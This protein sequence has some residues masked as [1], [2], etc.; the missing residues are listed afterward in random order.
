MSLTITILGCGSS[1]GVPRTGLQWGA[2]NPKNPKNWR[3]RCSILIQKIALNGAQTTVLIDTSPDMRMQLLDA[4]VKHL[5]AVLYTHG[6]ADHTH[7]IDDLRPL[8]QLNRQKIPVYC[9]ERTSSEL[10]EKFGYCFATPEGSSYP[11]MVT[12]HR[13]QPLENITINGAGG[14]L[15]FLPIPVNHG[16]IDAL[17][18]RF[19]DVCYLPDV[20]DIP[21]TS[22]AHLAGLKLWILDALRDTPHVSHFSV[23]DAL[24]W[25][26]RMR[27]QRAILTNLNIELDYDA[28]SAALPANIVAAYDGMT[29]E[30]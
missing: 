14:A 3:R 18:F 21:E 11:P 13:I 22:A 1:G 2:C 15:T 17:G 29:V 25:I 27:P 26:A 4:G 16:D 24:A 9:D 23:D 7:G 5:D 19:E 6:H 12:E 10:V 8:Y 30:I 20:K 28:L